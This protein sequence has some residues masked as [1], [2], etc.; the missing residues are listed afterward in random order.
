MDQK[1]DSDIVIK[2]NDN[3]NFEIVFAQ[4]WVKKTFGINF[5]EHMNIGRS[6]GY[7][8][9]DNSHYKYDVWTIEYITNFSS[10]KYEIGSEFKNG[11]TYFGEVNFL[12]FVFTCG[13]S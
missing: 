10:L 4:D 5:P 13:N 6:Y 8:I 1:Y 7:R 9:I 12:H 3:N 11:F 2:L